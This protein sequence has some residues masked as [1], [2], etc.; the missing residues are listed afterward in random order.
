MHNKDTVPVRNG[1]NIDLSA[2][3]QWLDKHAPELGRIT[4]ITQFPGGFSN[5]TYL[6][7]TPEKP[8]VLRRPPMGANIKSAHD[9]GREFKVLSLLKGHYDKI[10]APLVHCETPEVMGAPFYIMERLEGLILRP[11]NAPKLAL[12]P[13]Q[14]RTLSA[15]LVD[16]LVDIHALDIERCGLAPLGKPEGYVQ[17]QVE[18]WTKRYY[19]AE[20]ET[21]AALDEVAQWLQPNL[22][23]AQ[24]PAFLHNDYKFDNVL[25]DPTELRQVTG[26]LDWEMSTL[27]DPLMDLGAAL[28]WWIE[29][30][31]G[32]AMYAYNATWLP[33]NLTRQEA[34]AR[35][36]EKSGRNLDHIVFYYVFGL[37]K[38]AVI[39]QQI[40]ARWKQGLTQDP[41]FGHLLPMIKGLGEK[42]RDALNSG[43]I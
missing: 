25:F 35:Y 40:Y 13:E 19:A 17:R 27:G 37:F 39:G 24:M 22:P 33:G 1:E 3:Q 29:A 41:R 15:A 21:I 6:L 42:G 34:A 20:T 5:L 8:Y 30:G 11:N 26:V 32:T 12:S 16:N 18:G 36:A 43:K 2:L 10:P 28:A 31:D 4:A 7:E 38:N 9:M 23:P 14:W